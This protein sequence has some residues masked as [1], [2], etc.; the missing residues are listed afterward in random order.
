MKGLFTW[1]NWSEMELD[2][3]I[4]LLKAFSNEA[5]SL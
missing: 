5:F 2:I 3:V 1:Y 4:W